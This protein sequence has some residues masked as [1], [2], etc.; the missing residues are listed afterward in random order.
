MK[1][2]EYFINIIKPL[3]KKYTIINKKIDKLKWYNF[4]KK[5]MYYIL[6]YKYKKNIDKYYL[7][8][9]DIYLYELAQ[10]DKIIKDM[11]KK[12]IFN[13]ISALIDELWDKQEFLK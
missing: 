12:K 4:I 13:T 2:G 5:F 9:M 8:Y 1:S 6:K 7:T 10:N 3:E 11:K